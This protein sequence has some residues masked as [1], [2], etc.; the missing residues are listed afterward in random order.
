MS[1]SNTTRGA[2]SPQRMTQNNGNS[3]SRT[4]K[5]SSN[6]LSSLNRKNRKDDPKRA[7]WNKYL[8][9]LQQ[10]R[11]EITKLF[12]DNYMWHSYQLSIDKNKK[13]G[14]KDKDEEWRIFAEDLRTVREKVR[15]WYENLENKKGLDVA[16]MIEKTRNAVENNKVNYEV[17]HK[18]DSKR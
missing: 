18:P 16:Q 15:N 4:L 6:L 3:P 10:E 8:Q 14:T 13:D 1:Y 7:F 11:E 12:C 2:L 17:I 9:K 5:N